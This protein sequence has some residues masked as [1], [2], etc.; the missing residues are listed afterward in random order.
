MKWNKISITISVIS[1]IFIMYLTVN[2]VCEPKPD[3]YEWVLILGPLMGIITGTT[4]LIKKETHKWMGILSILISISLW[5]LMFFS[6]Q[7]C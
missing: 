7:L 3:I 2:L 4:S 6:P 1:F 5:I